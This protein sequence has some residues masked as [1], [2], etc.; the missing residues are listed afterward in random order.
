MDAAALIQTSEPFLRY[1]AA[2]EAALPELELA[3]VAAE[4]RRVAVVSVDVINGFCYTGNLASPRIQQIVA[5]IVALFDRAHAL[6]VEHIVLVQEAHEPDA[7][8]FQQFAPH[9]VRGTAEA[10]AV[11]EIRALPYFD[12]MTVIAKNSI[13]PALNTR[14]DEWLRG[15]PGLD[16]FIVVGDCT[17]LC[18]Y[19]TAMY[20]RLR[21][22]ALQMRQR[23]IVPADC[24]ETYDL[25]QPVAEQL[26]AL[27]HPGD[28]L[29]LVFLHSLALNGVEVVRALV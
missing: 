8:E 9:G 20:L 26:G 23:I 7:V 17:D 14:L 27:P 29:H 2:W 3:Q 5:P 4:P 11:P 15:R 6:G 10:E 12:R 18:I 16:T 19:Q 28:L 25:P 24:V 21:A 1:L 22:N 13:H